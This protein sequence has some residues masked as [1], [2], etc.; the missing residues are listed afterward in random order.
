MSPHT[1]GAQLN[2]IV[3][4]MRGNDTQLTVPTSPKAPE[5]PIALQRHRV[6]MVGLDA[7]PFALH[8]N[9]VRLQGGY[10][11]IR[12]GREVP[13]PKRTC[14]IDGVKLHHRHSH[15]L[16]DPSFTQERHLRR[17]L[18]QHPVAREPTEPKPPVRGQRHGLRGQLRLDL[19][20]HSG[21][22]GQRRARGRLRQ[23]Q[24][25]R[26]VIDRAAE[27]SD[28][29]QHAENQARVAAD[30]PAVDDRRSGIVSRQPPER[31][32]KQPCSK[33]Q[34]QLNESRVTVHRPRRQ[35]QQARPRSR[36]RHAHCE[37]LHETPC[38]RRRI[39]PQGAAQQ[40]GQTPTPPGNQ[41]NI[42]HLSPHHPPSCQI[43]QPRHDGPQHQSHG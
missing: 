43:E 2:W 23:H 7:L 29:K 16:I 34:P 12:T 22:C 32:Q 11:S 1:S 19:R 33:G 31:R 18:K 6:V 24:V 5:R 10:R 30:Q 4:V 27:Q 14:G 42:P 15:R 41:A 36:N 25:P 39:K 9:P 38:Q 17:G 35:R 20:L 21:H 40:P 28:P 26:P 8:A 37:G 3:P 13:D